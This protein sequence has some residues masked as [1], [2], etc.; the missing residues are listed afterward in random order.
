[1]VVSSHTISSG[2]TIVGSIDATG[3]GEEFII[4][5]ITVDGAW[6]SMRAEEAPT[7]SSM[8]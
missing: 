5:D 2:E 6:L 4:A 8:R 3:S 1:M 7:L